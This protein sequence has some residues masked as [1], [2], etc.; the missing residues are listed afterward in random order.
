M[1]RTNENAPHTGAARYKRKFQNLEGCHVLSESGWWDVIYENPS[2][3]ALPSGDV[4]HTIYADLRQKHPTMHSQKGLETYAKMQ[5]QLLQ[6]KDCACFLVETETKQ[7]QDI[8]WDIKIARH[9][10]SHNSIRITSI[11]QFYA[12]IANNDM[13]T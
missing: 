10:M 1:N 9:K 6:E 3:I 13:R 8:R 12:M 4:V 11:G 7:P 2:G 5:A